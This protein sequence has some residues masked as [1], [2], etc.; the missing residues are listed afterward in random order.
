MYI[1]LKHQKKYN[2]FIHFS[3]IISELLFHFKVSMFCAII[4]KDFENKETL[5]V[6]EHFV[7]VF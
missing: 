4:G 7:N 1:L 2:Y 3:Q 5:R 6:K